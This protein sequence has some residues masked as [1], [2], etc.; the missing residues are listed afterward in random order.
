VAPTGKSF[1]IMT[2]DIHELS[3]GKIVKSYHLEDWS[4]A[5]KQLLGN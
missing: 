3:N 1:H 5:V 4:T 2:I